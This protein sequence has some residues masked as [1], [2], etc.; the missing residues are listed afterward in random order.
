MR[1]GLCVRFTYRVP[2]KCCVLILELCFDYLNAT[3]G[4]TCGVVTPDD[5]EDLLCV[6]E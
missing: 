2:P 5:T 6:D 3:L 1:G 4:E